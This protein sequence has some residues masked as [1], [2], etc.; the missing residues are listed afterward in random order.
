MPVPEIVPPAPPL[1]PR[2]AARFAAAAAVAALLLVGALAPLG[3]MSPAGRM[4]VDARTGEME[5]EHAPIPWRIAGS[6]VGQLSV[7]AL[8]ASLVLSRDRLARRLGR[9]AR[10]LRAHA[11]V[12]VAVLALALAHTL[13]LVADGSFHGWVS[14][15]LALAALFAHGL[16]GARRRALQRAWGPWA[17]RLAADATAW[18]AVALTVEHVLLTSWHWG[19]ASWGHGA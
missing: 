7:L 5:F 9:R 19:F 11:W 14:G 17:W 15:V 3:S 8:A 1:P 13:L 18:A 2:V 12:G 16:L 4:V 10:V 6:V